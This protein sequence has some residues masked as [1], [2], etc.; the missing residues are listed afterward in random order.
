MITWSNKMTNKVK[1]T[2]L[3]IPIDIY[4]KLKEISINNDISMNR[5]MVEFIKRGIDNADSIQ[6]QI[7]SK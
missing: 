2:I 5:L 1:S 4:N 3:R 6:I 7:K